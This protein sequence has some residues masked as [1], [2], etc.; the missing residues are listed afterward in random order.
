VKIAAARLREHVLKAS[1]A[2]WPRILPDRYR[3]L[4]AGAGFGSS[5][6]S[7]PSGSFRVLYAADNFSTAFAEAVVRDRYE[8]KAKRILY[9][10]YLDQL[11]LTQISSSRALVLLDLRGAAAYDLGI[12][13]DTSRAR[14]HTAGQAFS[15][16]LY[17]I[18]ITLDGILFHS[19]LTTGDCLAIY[20]RAFTALSGTAPVALLQSALLPVELA[21]LGISVRSKRGFDRA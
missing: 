14:D 15:E 6:F 17:S 20:D 10:S 4:S 21:R 12:D 5:R 3:L 7:S 16:A 1:I 2:D 19:R 13:T 8:G 11:C 18:R 9:R